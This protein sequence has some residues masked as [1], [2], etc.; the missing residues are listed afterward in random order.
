MRAV[1]TARA[2]GTRLSRKKPPWEAVAR[3]GNRCGSNIV[4]LYPL[5]AGKTRQRSVTAGVHATA[6]WAGKRATAF[7]SRRAARDRTPARED[8]TPPPVPGVFGV[9]APLAGDGGRVALPGTSG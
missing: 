6:S 3:I 2:V 7:R 8:G 1:R 9:G 5:C 4:A